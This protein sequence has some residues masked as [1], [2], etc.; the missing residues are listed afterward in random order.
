MC[1][2]YTST[3]QSVKEVGA[4]TQA[5]SWRQEDLK[6]C[7]FGGSV[8]LLTT[9]RAASPGVAPFTVRWAFPHESLKKITAGQLGGIFSQLCVSS[10]SLAYVKF[11]CVQPVTL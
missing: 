4:G 1:G 9:P 3:S 5:E 2:L 7:S 8:C 11:T 10:K 6:G